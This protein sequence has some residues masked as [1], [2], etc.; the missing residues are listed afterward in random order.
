[1]LTIGMFYPTLITRW[2]QRVVF[3]FVRALTVFLFISGIIWP[4]EGM[5]P[6]FNKFVYLLPQTFSVKSM[7]AIITKAW[8]LNYPEGKFLICTLWNSARPYWTLYSIFRHNV[9]A[10][11]HQILT[12]H[13]IFSRPTVWYGFLSSFVW[14]LIFNTCALIVFRNKK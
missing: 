3:I 14:I 5:P 4:T 13:Q 1:M 11:V 9:N 2:A 6:V 8:G 10:I 7:R 12:G